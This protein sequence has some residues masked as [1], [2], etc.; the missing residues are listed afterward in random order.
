M[1]KCEGYATKDHDAQSL[2][3]PFQRKALAVLGKGIMAMVLTNAEI[4]IGPMHEDDIPRV[5][6][7]DDVS[8]PTPWPLD[9]YIHELRDNRLACYIV[10]RAIG[11]VVGYA[12][13]WIILDEAHVTTIAV[14][15][16]SER[17][18]A[19]WSALLVS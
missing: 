13:M 15:P 3:A 1:K 5:R 2:P 9:A 10:A 4:S 18:Q 11:A 19:T 8:F 14:A 7:I 6:E 17:I 12:G 16:E